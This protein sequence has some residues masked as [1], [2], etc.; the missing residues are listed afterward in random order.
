MYPEL[1]YVH[2]YIWFPTVSEAWEIVYELAQ[3]LGETS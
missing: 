1:L 3:N 2:I